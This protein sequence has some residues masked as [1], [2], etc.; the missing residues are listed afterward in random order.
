MPNLPDIKDA[1]YFQIA[2]Q[3]TILGVGLALREFEITPLQIAAIGATCFLAQWAGTALNAMRFD[4]RSPLITTLSLSLL[5]RA[6]GLLP[7]MIAAAIAI[8]SKFALRLNNKH[9]FN[10]A[11]A[12][13][14]A[15]LL[16]TDAAWT[17]PG[18]WGTALWFAIFIALAGALV[19]YKATRLDVPLIFLGAYAFLLF[20]RAL[21]LGDP[22]AIPLLRLQNGALILFAFFMISDPK[23]TPDGK[24]LR[25]A[26]S[27]GAALIAYVLTFH[28]YVTDGLFY[29]LAMMC[30]IRPLIELFDIAPRYQWGDRPRR[31]ESLRKHVSHSTGRA[32]RPAPAE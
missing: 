22:L 31:A 8:G 4:W 1:R 30:L 14:V 16:T 13:I 18:Q 29:A 25:A 5:L 27:A 19:T 9:I 11:N 24:A 15:M 26:F 7:L 21:W 32:P 2:G 12:G 3:A 6:D 28:F 17:T 20:A 23:T 10:P